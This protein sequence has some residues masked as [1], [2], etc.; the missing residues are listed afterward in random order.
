MKEFDVLR[1]EFNNPDIIQTLQFTNV[2]AGYYSM[3][4]Q[5]K[6]AYERLLIQSYALK[7][8]LESKNH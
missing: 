7:D 4:Q 3:I 2:F 1:G 8:L 5:R 6:N